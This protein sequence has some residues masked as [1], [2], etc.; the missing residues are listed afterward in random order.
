MP[1]NVAQMKKFCSE[2]T[3]I[4][5][6]IESFFR[7]CYS[8]ELVQTSKLALY[9]PKKVVAQFCP[10]S[11]KVSRRIEKLFK[12]A[13]CVNTNISKNATCLMRFIG[14]LEKVTDVG[15]ELEEKLKLPYVCW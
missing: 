5:N 11:N 12:L 8:K 13:S 15:A 2:S 14:E 6:Y 1:E 3:N 7:R 9:P 10:K 4:T